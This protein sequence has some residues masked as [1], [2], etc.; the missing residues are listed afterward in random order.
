[1]RLHYLDFDITDEDSGRCSFDAM[2]SVL[3]DR[4]PPLLDEIAA[5][6]RWAV[7]SFG[8]A[9]A[10]EGDGDWDYA[11]GATEEPDTPLELAF[12]VRKGVLLAP[13]P[14]GPDRRT[15]TL[16]LSGSPAFAEAFRR[17]FGIDAPD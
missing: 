9:G 1:M 16:T 3:P 4:L 15:L 2:A 13:W 11:L 5:V 6:L 14:K 8:A 12:D 10:L 7:A 17:H